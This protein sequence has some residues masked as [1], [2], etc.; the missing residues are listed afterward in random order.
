[1]DERSL[2]VEPNWLIRQ[3]IAAGAIEGNAGDLPTLAKWTEG[4]AHRQTGPGITMPEPYVLAPNEKTFIATL[5]SRF[6]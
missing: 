1:M 3:W 6:R 5:S 2:T 4:L